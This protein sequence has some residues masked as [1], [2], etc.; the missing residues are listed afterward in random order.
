M[1][2]WLGSSVVVFARSAKDPGFEPRS[3]HN[4]SPVTNGSH[5]NNPLW[6]GGHFCMFFVGEY[7]KFV[8]YTTGKPVT[9]VGIK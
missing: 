9:G 4:F 2:G 1:T 7:R 3:S 8:D 5:I 6:R